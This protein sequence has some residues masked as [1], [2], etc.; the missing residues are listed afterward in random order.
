M[1]CIWLWFMVIVKKLRKTCQLWPLNASTVPSIWI[2]CMLKNTILLNK[3]SFIDITDIIL[4]RTDQC[5]IFVFQ[6]MGCVK[7]MNTNRIVKFCASGMPQ[8]ERESDNKVSGREC[9]HQPTL[10]E[11]RDA[12]PPLLNKRSSLPCE[13][14]RSFQV[15]FTSCGIHS[16]VG[17]CPCLH[18]IVF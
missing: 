14:Q 6:P 18:V 9:E 7:W 8:S 11:E 2:H 3:N 17:L 5:S 15:R 4:A 16:F 12:S 1:V 10:K 13:G